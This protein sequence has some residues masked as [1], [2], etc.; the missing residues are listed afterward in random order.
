MLYCMPRPRLAVSLLVF[1]PHSGNAD[2]YS[3]KIAE[4]SKGAE[5]AV[6]GFVLPDG[7]TASLLA[8][9]PLLAN[10]VAFHVANDG[11]VFVCETFRQEVGV[12]DNRN[13]MNW[14]NNDL[15]L[16][17]VEERLAMF[18]KYLGVDV[19]K[20]AKEHD[21][22]RVLRDTDGDGRF[23]ADTVFA[24]GFNSILDGTGAGVIEHDGPHK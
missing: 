4:A 10:P 2:D 21:R 8:A 5:L 3:P 18:R 15:R 24:Q 22:I 6:Q 7:M 14:L 16:E 20:Y 23:D 19:A 12:E 17:S 13:H 9:E 1:L 11:R